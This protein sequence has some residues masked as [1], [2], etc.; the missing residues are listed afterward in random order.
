MRMS[1]I[2]VISR[3]LPI[4]LLLFFSPGWHNIS[5]DVGLRKGISREA[6]DWIFSTGL[7]FSFSLAT[8]S[9]K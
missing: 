2:S 1:P 9:H 3:K 4:V 7:T 5:L 8:I 6:A